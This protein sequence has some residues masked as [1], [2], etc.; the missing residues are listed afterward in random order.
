MTL[1]LKVKFFLAAA[2]IT[3]AISGYIFLTQRGQHEMSLLMR[4]V[5]SNNLLAMQAA[6]EIKHAFVFYDDLTFRF[7]TTGDA[8]LLAESERVRAKV[9]VETGRLKTLSDSPTVRSLL[10]ELEKESRQYFHDVQRLIHFYRI[11]QFPG[12]ENVLKAIA[13]ARTATRHKQSLTLLSA[14]G[15]SRLTR[16]YSLCESLVDLN[17]VQMEEAQKQAN[18]ILEEST[19]N[20]QWAGAAVFSGTML[21]GAFLMLSILTPIQALLSGVRRI[22]GGDMNFQIPSSGSDEIGRLT[23]AFNSMTQSLREKHQ[24]LF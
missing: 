14:E 3:L 8:T 9:H 23:A 7:I 2:C 15:R 18:R 24:E 5:L 19:K 20:T 6:S 12:E 4:Q 22:M 16:I 11:N 10:K 1:S 13:W 17:R 21:I